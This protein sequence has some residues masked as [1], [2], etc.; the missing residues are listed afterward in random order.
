MAVCHFDM[1][2]ALP[3]VKDPFGE[4]MERINAL[5]EAGC[6]DATFSSNERGFLMGS[7]ARDNEAPEAVASAI[8]S[9][10]KALPG[11]EI[12]RIDFVKE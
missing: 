9:V 6:D 1:L 5:Y 7:F 12:V 4:N 11:A 8:K 2:I 3:D 10:L